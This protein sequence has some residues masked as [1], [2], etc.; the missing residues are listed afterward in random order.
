MASGPSRA[1]STSVGNLGA[2][3]VPETLL[4]HALRTFLQRC[5][6]VRWAN[7]SR[8]RAGGTRWALRLQRRALDTCATRPFLAYGDG[9][10][11]H[12][13]GRMSRPSQTMT[14]RGHSRLP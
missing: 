2:A 5:S 9:L 1:S 3:T 13:S 8:R 7:P 6:W 10:S 14:G 11:S 4:W 12:A